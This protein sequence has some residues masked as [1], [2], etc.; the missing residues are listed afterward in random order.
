MTAEAQYLSVKPSQPPSPC[1]GLGL[2]GG[3]VDVGVGRRVLLVADD[4]LKSLV[5]HRI[6]GD[7]GH[8]VAQ[9]EP[10]GLQRRGRAARID[11]RVGDREHV[12]VVDRDDALED[13]ARAVVPG[14]RHRLR[15]GSAS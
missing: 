11:D 12:F 13:E 10:V 7:I 3:L 15:Q 14:Q 9:D 4:A 5:Q 2:A 1:V 8:A 6:A